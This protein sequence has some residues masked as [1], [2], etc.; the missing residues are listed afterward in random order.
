VLRGFLKIIIPCLLLVAV[1]A[2][3]KYMDS[4]GYALRTQSSGK[5][6]YPNAVVQ[7][8]QPANTEITQPTE[9]EPTETTVVTEPEQTEPVATEPE[10]TVSEETIPEETVPEEV[11]QDTFVF[12]FLGDCTF[13]AVPSAYYAEVGFV[14][15]IGEDYLY[16]FENV[17]QYMENDDFT[18]LNLEGPLTDVG[19]PIVSRYTFRGPE[20][21]VNILTMN[22]VE[23]VTLANNHTMDYGIV[24]MENTRKVLDEA[25]IPYVEKD[26]SRVITLDSGLTVGLYATMYANLDKA[27]MVSEIT[28][29]REQGVDVII[30]AAH[31]GTEGSYRAKDEQKELAYA[32][33]DAGANIVFGTHPHVLQPIEEYNGGVI[34]YSM[35]NF[36]FGGHQQL[37]DMDTAVVQQVIVREPDGTVTLGERNI[38]PCSISSEEQFNNYQPTPYAEDSEEYNRVMEKLSGTFEG[39]DL[40]LN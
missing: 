35:A 1:L 19:N 4:A 20:R 18:F 34:L 25:Q 22:S 21:F 12:T 8:T 6:V 32:A 17:R 39:R 16:P 40:I 23:G 37:R 15:T 7:Q 38:I 31:W 2:A 29:M 27:D 30:Y 24:G 28:A 33:I 36:S 9:T 5:P 11:Q 10:E 3:A 13:G 14:K 26:C